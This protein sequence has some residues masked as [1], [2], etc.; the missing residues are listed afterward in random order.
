MTIERLTIKM[1]EGI[2]SL[3]WIFKKSVAIIYLFSK[4]NLSSCELF[5]SRS[6]L[7]RLIDYIKAFTDVL[8]TDFSWH[9]VQ[10][11]KRIIDKTLG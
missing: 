1:T 6:Y 8:P 9:K 4:Q 2:H 5:T 3:S 10:G 7:H 11:E